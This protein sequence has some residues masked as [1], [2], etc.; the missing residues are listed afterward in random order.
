VLLHSGV[1]VNRHPVA[2][3]LGFFPP[4]ETEEQM[5]DA[6]PESS[7]ATILNARAHVAM[8]YQSYRATNVLFSGCPDLEQDP[9]RKR[10]MELF[11]YY[12]RTRQG[13]R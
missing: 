9:T 13:A 11:K 7:V 4:E 10:L 6:L 12:M 8:N 3:C 1:T 5:R 2:T